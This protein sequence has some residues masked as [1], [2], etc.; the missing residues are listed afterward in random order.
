MRDFI[1]Y[2]TST[3]H[4]KDEILCDP[5][6]SN[7]EISERVSNQ[8]GDISEGEVARIRTQMQS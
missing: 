3:D 2:P 8:T 5:G 7:A 4:A 1:A 6:A